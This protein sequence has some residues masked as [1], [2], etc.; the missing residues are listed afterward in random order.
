[1]ANAAAITVG[2]VGA[3]ILM[4][5]ISRALIPP[6][7]TQQQVEYLPLEGGYS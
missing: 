3:L 2:V 1:M 6:T 4:G 5:L 7:T